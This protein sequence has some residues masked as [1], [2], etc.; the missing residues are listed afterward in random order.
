MEAIVWTKYGP[1]DGRQLREIE[2]PTPKDKEVLVRLAA[3][4]G[5]AGDFEMRSLEIPVLI[6]LPKRL[7]MG[8]RKPRGIIL[9]QELAGE[10][11]SVG[12][13][14]KLF[15]KGDQVFASTGFVFGAYAE[16]KRL[17]ED[18]KIGT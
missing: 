3:T 2:K 5:I 7:D 12:K 8:F 9:G 14:G 18:P 15:K 6:R 1:P 10:I 16:D 17:P 13:D 4:T 11:E